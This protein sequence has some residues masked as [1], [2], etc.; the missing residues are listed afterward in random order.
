[1][2]GMDNLELHDNDLEDIEL[3]LEKVFVAFGISC[4]NN[5]MAHI[6]TFGEMC[7]Y[8]ETK[9]NREH[10]GDCTTQQA[11]YKLRD[12]FSSVLKVDTSSITPSTEI[13]NLLPAK[14]RKKRISQIEKRIGIKMNILKVPNRITYSLI[15]HFLLSLGILFISTAVGLFGIAASIVGGVL[16]RVFGNELTVDDIGQLAQKITNEHYVNVRRNPQTMNKR[17][18][19]NVIMNIFERELDVD[20]SKLTNDAR[21]RR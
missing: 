1:M 20:A 11:F 19:R 15:L 8:I 10:V 14:H 12:A 18:V 6:Q 7:D 9:I 2:P 21:L 16:A 13:A 5:E 17:E 3:A 4:V